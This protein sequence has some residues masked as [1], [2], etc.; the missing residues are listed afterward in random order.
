MSSAL[1]PFI[2]AQPVTID[3]IVAI[4]NNGIITQSELDQRVKLL[5][6]RLSAQHVSLPPERLL[7]RRVLGQMVMERLELQ[8]AKRIGIHISAA[9]VAAA[10]ATLAARNHMSVAQFEHALSTEGFTPHAFHQRLR[11]ELTIRALI[12]RHISRGVTVSKASVDRFMAEERAAAGSRYKIAEITLSVPATAGQAARSRI[13]ARAHKIADG[14]AAGQAF[15]QAAIEHSED[16][17][18]LEGGQ[19]GWRRADHLRPLFVHA[20]SRMKIGEVRVL[21]GRDAVYLVKLENEKQGKQPPATWQVR[22][23]EI[24]L[25]PTV[26]M[27]GAMVREKLKD[28]KLRIQG[29]Q[30]FGALARAYSEAGNALQGGRTGWVSLASLPP[31]LAQAAQSLPIGQV[32]GPYAMGQGQILIQVE[33]RRLR[34]GLTR[35]AAKRLLRMRKG[36]T[37]YVRWLQTLRDDAYIRYMRND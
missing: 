36:S 19:L 27:S 22:L 2:S 16:Q 35:S 34:H 20:V 23:R 37:L 26:R 1:P 15:S 29:G 9:E 30:S 32:G 17:H 6:E 13:L 28:L 31:T 24:I 33:S 10:E 14:I 8:Y 18:A 11:R 25:R 4:V 7:R 5:A 3:K 21:A 12:E